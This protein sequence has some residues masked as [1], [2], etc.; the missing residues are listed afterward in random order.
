MD[1]PQGA[2]I[3]SKLQIGEE[4][5]V[6]LNEIVERYII[7]CNKSLKEAIAHPKFAVYNTM[8]EL[9]DAVKKEKAEEPHKIPYRFTV[10]EL[11]PQ[12]LVLGYI[13]KDKLCKE[14]IKVRFI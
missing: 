5:F 8:T 14:F 12:H 2:S 13:P 7:P 4:E 11:Y 3:G 9:E 6:S 10:M 1:K